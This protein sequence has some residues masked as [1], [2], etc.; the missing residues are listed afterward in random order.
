MHCNKGLYWIVGCDFVCVWVV[1]FVMSEV[2]KCCWFVEH[3]I[4]IDGQLWFG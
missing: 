3:S 2:G 1:L 4:I